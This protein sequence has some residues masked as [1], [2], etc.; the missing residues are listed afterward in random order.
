MVVAARR[1]V[2]IAAG[3]DRRRAACA[4]AGATARYRSVAGYKGIDSF[5]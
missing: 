1:L 4:P 2:R 3:S 5:R